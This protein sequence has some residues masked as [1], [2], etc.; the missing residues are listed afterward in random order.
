LKITI[1]SIANRARS[2][3]YDAL[4][5]LYLERLAPYVAIDTAIH[6]TESD[7]F[8]A[9]ARQQKRTLPLVVLLDSRG[10][11]RSSEDFG[12]WI[13]A[14]R[15]SDIQNLIFAIG[16]ASGWSDYARSRTH[17][18]L[19]LGPMTMPHELVRVVLAE[20]LYRAFTILAG[21]PYHTGH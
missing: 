9:V 2:D 19:S 17:L 5:S 3:T 13:G 4:T 1:A 8:E 20:Q 16:P 14:Q 18:L 6:R 21:H 10:K 7:F 11:L 12:A 15:D